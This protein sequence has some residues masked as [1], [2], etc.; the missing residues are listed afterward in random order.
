MQD[1]VFFC[2]F[3]GTISKEDTIQKL[4]N[5]YA[6]EEWL[7]IEDDW[8]KQKIGSRECLTRQIE[9]IDSLSKRNLDDFINNIEIDKTFINFYDFLNKNNQKMYIVSDGF[10]LFIKNVLKNAGI[11]DIDI[12]SNELESQDNKLYTAFPYHNKNC[13]TRAGMCKCDIIKTHS[14]GKNVVYI[15][16][17]FS[18]I[19]AIKNADMIFAKK[20]LAEY[21]ENNK[22]KYT[23]FNDFN[24]IIDELEKPNEYKKENLNAVIS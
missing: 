9:C 14:H 15:G 2:D 5:Q 13:I 16:D 4:L 22:I 1:N 6:T 19:C 12:F 20:R 17:G 24:D 18:D 10:N 7:K 11:T 21:C 3:D 23:F 8:E